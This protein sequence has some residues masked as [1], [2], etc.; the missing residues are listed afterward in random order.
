MVEKRGSKTAIAPHTLEFAPACKQLSLV[1]LAIFLISFTVTWYKVWWDT[2]IS[3]GV[4]LYGYWTLRDTNPANLNPTRVRRFHYGTILSLV[5]HIIAVGE[6]TYCVIKL[7]LL[8]KIVDVE[9][10]P[11]VPL[12]VFLYL[13][14]LF[15]IGVTSF[16]V[17]R[18]YN[19]C[20][21]ISRNEYFLQSEAR[22]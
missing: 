20:Q 3:I 1:L 7:Y 22:V 12:F 6:T 10:G 2:L 21:E 16:A 11:G 19:L 15:E 13:F 4:M 14:L 9:E 18:T 17:E 8:D 5:C